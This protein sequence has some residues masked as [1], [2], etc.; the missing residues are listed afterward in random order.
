[1]TRVRLA[2]VGWPLT[3]GLLLCTAFLVQAGGALVGPKVEIPV[4]AAATFALLALLNLLVPLAIQPLRSYAQA[5]ERA[6]K[7]LEWEAVRR[8][9]LEGKLS[10]LARVVEQT[11]DLVMITD[12]RGVIDYV[13]PA[14]ERLTG[15]CL[16]E[17]RGRTPSLLKS[18]QQTPEY[19]RAMWETILRG[20]SFHGILSN[21]RKNGDLFYSEKTISP[22]RND[23][24]EI[25]QFVSTDRDV[26][27]RVQMEAELQ[28]KT[29]E[30]S[31]SNRELDGFSSVVCHDLKEPL[32][33]IILQLQVLER[34]GDT[35][36]REPIRCALRMGAMLDSLL[37]F[38]Q[39]GRK[40]I[41]REPVEAERLVAEAVENLSALK[42]EA[43]A[44]VEWGRLPVVTG[45]RVQLVGLFQNLIANGIKFRGNE[46][47]RVRIEGH[48]T[49]SG[50]EFSVSDNGIGLSEDQ[51]KELFKPFCRLHGGSYPGHGL[52]LAT[53]KAIAERHGGRIW[54]ESRPGLGSTFHFEIGQNAVS[55][56]RDVPR[57]LRA[58][59]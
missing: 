8:K 36:L 22:I 55:P 49:E 13:N 32:R 26:T 52:G 46:P 31:R 1:M 41:S 24:G 3:V 57:D 11:A 40:K 56:G 21:K 47:P 58:R 18:G 37:S 7:K 27:E 29:D 16:E 23:A 44:Q 42:A 28:A 45:D 35:K 59:G 53:C 34:A 10:K 15:Y 12:V 30:L 14:F 2:L 6:N 38:S 54:V 48:E 39:A 19:Y 17:A 25:V 50:W 43:G 5:L 20:E 33:T 4:V 9:A 51:C